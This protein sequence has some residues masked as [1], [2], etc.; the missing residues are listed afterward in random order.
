[1]NPSRLKKLFKPKLKLVPGTRLVSF[2]FIGVSIMVAAGFLWAANLYYNID[3]GE[4][5]MEEIQRVTG[6]IR[7]TAGLVI[8]GTATQDPAS[9]TK[10]EVASGDV[11][12]SAAD[13][14]LRFSGGTSYYVG[15]KV[16]TTVT[17]TK[18]YILPQHG[19]SPPS[20]DYVLTWQSGD[21]L[22][23]KAVTSTA[24]AGDITDV[25]DVSTGAAFTS[26]GSGTS[27]WFH[28]GAYTG[29]LT[30]GTLNASRTYTLPDLSGTVALA[31]STSFTAGGVLFADSSGLI[32]QDASN[33]YWDDTQNRLGILT[34][35]PDYS[36]DVA[37]VI[38]SGRGG[39]SGQIR[40]YSEQGG[41][42][43]EVILNPTS[44][45]TMNT[46]YYLPSDVGS[47]NEVL[48]TDG[49]GILTWTTVTGTG[50]ITGSGTTNRLA[51]FT[52]TQ[53]IGNASILDSYTGGVALTIATTTGNISVDVGN[54]TISQGI[55]AISTTT[56]TSTIS[57]NLSIG[58]TLA[59]V[60]AVLSSSVYSPLFTSYG[61]TT[62]G[63]A[64]AYDII[65]DP[66]S[67]TIQI[68]TG[69]VIK[70]PGGHPIR[71]SGEQILR[72]MIPILGFDL[73]AQTAT[74]SYV[75]VSRVL[76]DYSFA[77]ALTGTT[78]VHKFV[79]RYADATT[80]ASTTWR[81]YNVTDSTTTAT[82][83]VPATASTDLDKGE[84][85]IT[86]AVT[87]PTDTD[88]WRLDLQTP[89]STIRVYQVFLAAYDQVD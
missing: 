59:G 55:L 71:A 85:Y 70:T 29:Q 33:L 84:A 78:R 25:G 15:L 5:V 77:S 34:N 44:T 8:G 83:Q 57:G 1:M 79:I 75:Q 46:T 24:G 10:L 67:G 31:T 32:I 13:Q 9:G 27:L 64:G 22:Q 72:E 62:I 87:I 35:S 18:T 66:G 56:A 60:T 14:I 43:Y 7:A 37:G 39:T 76:E 3:T 16:P 51:K 19:T 4:V 48:T 63:S 47:S 26:G 6:N 54:L 53:Q 42:D 20:A 12:L 88:D 61:T 89:G 21:Q 65:L 23:W 86:S 80:T 50:A 68:A 17:S 81:V 40:I 45:M 2:L 52:D 58:G 74:T 82:F 28:N 49:S 11:L 73:P 36:L 41:T 69:D 30:I 38:R